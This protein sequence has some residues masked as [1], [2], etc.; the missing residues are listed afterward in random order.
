MNCRFEKQ[1]CRLRQCESD[2]NDIGYGR[3]YRGGD[4]AHGTLSRT[5]QMRGPNSAPSMRRAAS[6]AL[7]DGSD[8]QLVNLWRFVLRLVL[9]SI[10]ISSIF[11]NGWGEPDQQ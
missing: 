4:D 9:L 7:A 1:L 11:S 2:F 10:V 8:R 6:P 3:Q 5:T